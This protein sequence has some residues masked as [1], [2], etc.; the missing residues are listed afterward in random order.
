[1][2]GGQFADSRGHFFLIDVENENEMLELLNRG[3]LDTCSIESHPV[4][5]FKDLFNFFEGNPVRTTLLV[6]NRIKQRP[7]LLSGDAH[8]HPNRY[9]LELPS[10]DANL[11]GL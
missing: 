6:H 5:S 10:G 7:T 4:V 1:M 8:S 9:L 2:E 3:L 11:P